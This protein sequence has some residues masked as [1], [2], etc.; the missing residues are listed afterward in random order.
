MTEFII[1]MINAVIDI[2]KH[3][4]FLLQR[5]RKIKEKRYEHYNGYSSTALFDI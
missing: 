1:Q 5:P 3:I 2:Y 4:V